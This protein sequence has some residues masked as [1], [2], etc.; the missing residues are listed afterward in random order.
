MK[1]YYS[2]KNLIHK[3]PFCKLSNGTYH[4]W[5]L[6]SVSLRFLL[7]LNVAYIVHCHC[8]NIGIIVFGSERLAGYLIILTCPVN[9][10]LYLNQMKTKNAFLTIC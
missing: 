1:A 3:Q 6:L 2:E 5:E 10:K 8:Q 9:K 7:G 4:T